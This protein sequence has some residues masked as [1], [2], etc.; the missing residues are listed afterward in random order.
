MA[1]ADAV[2]R[3][4]DTVAG[5]AGAADLV[6]GIAT[7]DNRET[8]DVVV[9]TVLAGIAGRL[10]PW[11]AVVVNADGGS[12]DGTPNRV[13]QLVGSRAPLVQIS[14]PIYPV[15]KL[16][17]PLAGVPG[18]DEAVRA[19]FS[20]AQKLGSK[21]C[22][23]LDAGARGIPPEWIDLL[24]R[25]VLERDF[26]FVASLYQRRKFEGAIHSGIVYPL[27]RALYGR[28]IRE[29]L[30]GDHAFS[31]K[32][33][34]HCAARDGWDAQ[35]PLSTDMWLAVQAISTGAR[36]CQASLGPRAPLAAEP[37]PDLSTTLSQVLA[38]LFDGMDRNAAFWQRVRGSEAVPVFG[39][40]P[41]VSREAVPLNL[42]RM[43][44]SFRL[45]CRDLQEIWNLVLP[46]ATLFEFKRLSRR[47]EEQ[48]RMADD[49][50][51][52]AIYDFSLGYRLRVIDR[53]HLLAA[54]A[55]IYLGWLAS[56]AAEMQHAGPREL[57]ERL[58]R[59]CMAFEAQKR[60]L[61]SRW[62]W[63]DRFNP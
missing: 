2:S 35:T 20:I 51:A 63:P 7:Y 8:I 62:R 10:S 13:R 61:I 24:A 11:R 15:H 52:R 33:I 38:A 41:Q 9:E 4:V 18:K 21:A 5:E 31:A 40:P 32:F 3:D 30:G 44:E 53:G 36:I 59:L 29:P 25:P 45:G 39:P 58:E 16:S 19:T 23:L 57:E 1:E 37:A 28:R 26:D 56:Y 12:G 49:V 54:F 46:P 14:Y 17:T 50:W 43:A 27:A 42:E 22:A 60:Y 47:P 48:F 34:E 6:V 55:P